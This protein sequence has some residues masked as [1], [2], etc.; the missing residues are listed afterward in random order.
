[1]HDL[2][3]AARMHPDVVGEAILAD[4]QRLEKLFK[5]N[6]TGMSGREFLAYSN[7]LAEFLR[8]LTACWP[9]LP[10]KPL[11]PCYSSIWMKF[12]DKPSA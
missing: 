10:D 12:P 11:L 7:L 5:K 2:I 8:S 3:D 1:M 9:A 6:L 4:P